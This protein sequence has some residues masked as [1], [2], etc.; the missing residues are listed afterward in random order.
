M[1]NKYNQ[2]FTELL[3]RFSTDGEVEESTRR[4]VSQVVVA[5]LN[6]SSLKNPYGIKNEIK[7]IIAKEAKKIS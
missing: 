6:K 3:S 7:E 5:E 2:I 1:S 4:I